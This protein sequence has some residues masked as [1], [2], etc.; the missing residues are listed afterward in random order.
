MSEQFKKSIQ[1]RYDELLNKYRTSQMNNRKKTLEVDYLKQ[2]NTKLKSEIGALKRTLTP[3]RNTYIAED[4]TIHKLREI[5]ETKFLV[6]ISEIRR[7]AEIVY[8]RQLFHYWLI[9]NTNKTLKQ[10]GGIFGHDH[11]TTIN[12]RRKISDYLSYDKKVIK[13]YQD[14]C[15]KMKGHINNLEDVINPS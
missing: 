9:M 8:A 15:L 3:Y 12:S 1:E 7:N 5:I 6:D 10:I 4:S 13:D 2:Q 14:I 11:S